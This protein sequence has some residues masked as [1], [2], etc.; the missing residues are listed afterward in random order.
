MPEFNALGIIDFDHLEFAVRDLEEAAKLYIKL[1][2]E[3]IGTRE[4]LERK[5]NSV[6]MGQND[7]RILLSHSSDSIDPVSRYVIKHGDGVCN[8]AF[9]C[10]NAFS[11]F[12]VA[13]SRG[14]EPSETPKGY[15]KDFGSVDVAS[16][17]AFGD[18]TH[19]FVAR[20]GGLFGEGFDSA[21]RQAPSGKGL[22]RIDHI[23]TNVEKGH[24][25]DWVG[26]YERVFGLKNT[27]FFDIH[28]ERSGLYSYVM[29]SP[30]GIIKMPFNEPTEQ[31]SQ[32][33]EFI[34]IHHGPGVQHV[35]LSTSDIVDSLTELRESTLSFL[36]TPDAY[37][38]ALPTRLPNLEENIADL[39]TLGILADGDTKGY[40]L[41][42]FT[43]NVVGP[44]FY[45]IIQRKGNDGFGEGNFTAL[46]E[47]IERDQMKRGVMKS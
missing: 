35:A 18:V 44:F 37:Y 20:T 25:K 14:A 34:D 29:Q 9:L 13:L 40:L 2:F 23:T 5:L 30:N 3:K 38:E 21:A 39:R 17:K 1:G 12:E 28:T 6:L 11:A 4:V 36:S 15:K 31:A 22:L 10:Q 16:I 19:S 24:I 32:I 27:R 43:Q 46:F 45:E 7:I 41:Q 42:I 26:F 33:Q 8:V 47:A